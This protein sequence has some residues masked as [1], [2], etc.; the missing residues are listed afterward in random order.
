VTLRHV[1]FRSSFRLSGKRGGIESPNISHVADVER[2]RTLCGR[3]GWETNEGDYDPS[4]GVDCLICAKLAPK[5]L[6]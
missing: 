4:V 3:Q 1:L 6:S 5:E 2:G